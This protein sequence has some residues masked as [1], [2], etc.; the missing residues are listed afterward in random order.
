MADFILNPAAPVK[1]DTVTFDGTLSFDPNNSTGPD[2]GIRRW[3][4]SFGD[5]T[6]RFQGSLI[7]HKF[8]APPVSPL[9]GNFTVTLI[10][11]DYGDGLASR[12]TVLVNVSPGTVHDI[13]LSINASANELREGEAVR[14]TLTVTNN[15][16][17]NELANLTVTYN[18]QGATQIGKESMVN[19]TTLSRQKA[20]EYTLQT[21]GLP[22]R[23][24]AVTATGFIVNATTGEMVP[25]AKP[26]D[27]TSIANFS[28][29][30]SGGTSSLSL[31]IFLG[32]GVAGVLGG[33]WLVLRLARRKKEET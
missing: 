20:F 24:Y 1:N 8:I 27:N 14:L 26:L 31:P 21:G 3:L 18:Y 16:N 19:L 23:Q 30:A 12:K 11:Y 10:V 6:G 33:T 5:G 25:D 9:A 7:N 13:A 29:Q 15:G 4:W 22:A 28:L 17:R 32:V 2:K